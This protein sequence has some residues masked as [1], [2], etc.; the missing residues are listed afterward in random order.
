MKI[1]NSLFTSQNAHIVDSGYI[2][3]SFKVKREVRQGDPLSLLL[4]ILAINPFISTI[5]ENVK[6]ILVNNTRFRI[7]AYADDI[8]LGIRSTS[9]WTKVLEILYYYEKASNIK[10]NKAKS[11]LIP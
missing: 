10:I 3:E 11:I 7:T 6:G 5:N 9:D 2:S 1:I 4:Y 8:L